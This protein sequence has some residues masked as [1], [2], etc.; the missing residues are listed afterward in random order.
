MRIDKMCIRDRRMFNPFQKDYKRNE[1]DWNKYAGYS[2]QYHI[3]D[4]VSRL[5]CC[6][7]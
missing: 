5:F 6:K 3:D 1:E 7:K 4:V 2:Y